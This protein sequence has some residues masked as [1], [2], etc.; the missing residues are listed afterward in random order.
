MPTSNVISWAIASTVVLSG[1]AVTTAG[2]QEP[3][4]TGPLWLLDEIVYNNDTTTVPDDPALYSVQFFDD[5][6]L[7]VRADCN[8]GNGIYDVDS[9]DFITLQAF[10]LAACGPDSLDDEFRQG[11]EEAVN[12]FFL[13]GDLYMDLPVDTGTMKFIADETMVEEEEDV[14]VEEEDVIV[15]EE[16]EEEPVM[17]EPETPEPTEES[18]PIPGLW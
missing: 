13:D 16:V 5:G 15:E 6:S 9:P 7:G 2:A 4:L 1:T 8:V 3:T 10:T 11:L 12:Y 18:E 17:V 14:I